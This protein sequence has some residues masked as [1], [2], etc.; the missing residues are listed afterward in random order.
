ML[1][2]GSL[3]VTL[4]PAAAVAAGAQWQVDGGVWQSSAATVSGLAPGNHAVNYQTVLSWTAPAAEQVAITSGATTSITRTYVE[5]TGSVQVTLAPAAAITAGAQWNVDGGAWQNSGATVSGLTLGNHTINYNAIPNWN[6]PATALPTVTYNTTV[7]VTGTYAQ[8]TRLVFVVQPGV[9]YAAGQAISGVQVAIQDANGNVVTTSNAVVALAL[10]N[11]NGATLN[12]TLSQPASSGVATFTGLSVNKVGTG[13]GLQATSSGLTAAASNSFAITPGAAASL[14]FTTQPPAS[15]QAGQAFAPAVTVLDAY[16]NPVTSSTATVALALT[17]ANGATL[18]GT[19][20]QSASSG[21]ATFN[22]LS[23]NK[24]GTGY[25]L[26]AT[27]TGLTGAAS[28]SFAVTPGAAASLAFTT[29]PPASSQA[30]Q[31]FAPAVTVLDAYNNTVTTSAASIAVALTNANGATLNGTPSQSASSGVATFTGL[32]VN[33]AGTAY[34]LQA[35]SSGLTAAA[36]SSFAITPGTASKLGFLVSPG[37][38]AAGVAL[39]PDPQVAV[40]DNYGNTVTTSTAQVTVALTGGAPGAVLGGT[41]P[42]S[43]VGG[44]ATF[45]DLTV[46]LAS[47]GYQLSASASGLTGALSSAFTITGQPVLTIAESHAPDPVNAGATV[48]FTVTYGNIGAKAGTNEVIAETLPA[49]LAF[50]SATG[51][52]TCSNGVITWTIPSLA[53]HTTGQTVAFEATVDSAMTQGGTITNSQL[54]ILC[55]ESPTPVALSTPD[56]VNVNETQPPAVSGEYPAP[57]DQYVASMASIKL[58]VT[59]GGTGVNLSTVQITASRDGGATT[60]TICDGNNLAPAAPASSAASGAPYLGCYDATANGNTVFKGRTYIGGTTAADYVFLFEPDTDAAFGF[61]ETVTVSVSATDWAGNTMTPS[62]ASN[63]P[64]L[65]DFTIEPRNF[66]C[67]PRVDGGTPGDVF[68]ATA[69][70]ATGNTWVAWERDAG[71]SGTIWLAERQDAADACNF[72][73]EIRLRA[74]RRTAIAT[75]RPSPSRRAGRSTRLT[76]CIARRRR[77]SAS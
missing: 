46:N 54:T 44:V 71:A 28:N 24:V 12:G 35:T 17:N 31:A 51:G 10:T 36:S 29:Q 2:P 48:T 22:G 13:Y 61:D 50:A 55:T 53:A 20:S 6:S 25:G 11:A 52:G 41:W 70:D 58:H 68:P 21:V 65:Y 9:S 1:P 3:K 32:S 49:H 40:Q 4:L 27:S 26:Q 74:S 56:V 30:G 42:V 19:L 7:V 38:N 5:Q 23:V 69:T 57:G 45:T 59:D 37:T 47:T 77:P 43:A 14:A 64:S 63:P 60:E 73:P 66:G 39:S 15:S 75:S 67:N 72:G 18:S 16:N 34:A 33:M 62:S 76:K 8:Q